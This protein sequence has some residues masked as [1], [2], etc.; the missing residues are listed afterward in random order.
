MRVQ[1]DAPGRVLTR[2]QA[3]IDRRTAEAA[4]EKLS[5]D[6]AELVKAHRARKHEARRKARDDAARRES[7]QAATR[8]DITYN[9][10]SEGEASPQAARFAKSPGSSEPKRSASLTPV[11]DQFFGASFGSMLGFAAVPEDGAAPDAAAA[12][13]SGGDA[14]NSEASREDG[15]WHM[16]RLVRMQIAV[17]TYTCARN[18]PRPVSTDRNRRARAG[19]PPSR[20]ACRRRG[21]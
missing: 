2:E 16:Y 15:M 1:Y 13:G 5:S 6:E 14:S 10:D 11:T 7:A 4:A 20:F 12:A 19:R 21:R 8:I 3:E 9:A 17:D 18:L